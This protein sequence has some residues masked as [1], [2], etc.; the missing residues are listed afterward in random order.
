VR[1]TFVNQENLKDRIR[2]VKEDKFVAVV[3]RTFI[4]QEKGLGSKNK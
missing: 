3:R 2:L 1:R 4:S